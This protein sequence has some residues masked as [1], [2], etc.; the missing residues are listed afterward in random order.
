MEITSKETSAS[1]P[2]ADRELPMR[3]H[4]EISI[5]KSIFGMSHDTLKW[6]LRKP[7]KHSPKL[8]LALHAGKT[9]L[10][11]DHGVDSVA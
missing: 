4:H 8:P 3:A 2:L 7:L 9:L 10:D 1:Q 5:T 11:Q 6:N